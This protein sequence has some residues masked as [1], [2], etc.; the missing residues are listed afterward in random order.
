MQVAIV[1]TQS[2]FGSVLPAANTQLL[3]AASMTRHAEQ[4]MDAQRRSFCACSHPLLAHW[5]APVQ[6]E[7]LASFAW[8]ALTAVL[9]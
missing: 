4:V 9:Q 8:H 6:T 2:F 3:P 1:P 7:P 5:L